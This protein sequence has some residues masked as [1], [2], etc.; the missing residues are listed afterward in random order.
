[1]L[2]GF[3]LLV[4]CFGIA[5][6]SYAQSE[7]EKLYEVQQIEARIRPQ[8]EDTRS[9]WQKKLGPAF[10]HLFK[11]MVK[12]YEE[13]ATFENLRTLLKKNRE[14]PPQIE[15]SA[16]AYHKESR[17]TIEEEESYQH[18]VRQSDRFIR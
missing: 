10:W 5:F 4:G 1:M 8:L 11:G 18:E 2:A 17:E 3:V 12:A 7:T 14:S 15:I 9:E 13:A 16:E 6:L